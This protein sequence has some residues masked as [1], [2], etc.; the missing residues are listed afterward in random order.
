MKPSDERWSIPLLFFLLL[1]VKADSSSN[2]DEMM[3]DTE[4]ALRLLDQQVGSLKGK[5]K[6]VSKDEVWAD[7]QKLITR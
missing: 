7:F 2:E 4:K 6:Q 1:S 5:P 3:S